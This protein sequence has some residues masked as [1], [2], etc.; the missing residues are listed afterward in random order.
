MEALVYICIHMHINIHIHIWAFDGGW[1]GQTTAHLSFLNFG[2]PR[3]I[4]WGFPPAPPPPVWRVVNSFLMVLEVVGTARG[5]VQGDLLNFS[6]FCL[7]WCTAGFA[8]FSCFTYTTMAS[9]SKVHSPSKF[10]ILLIP[11]LLAWQKGPQGG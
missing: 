6:A 5:L 9:P 4:I 2:Q 8:L 7:H 3:R 10:L 11:E 1:G